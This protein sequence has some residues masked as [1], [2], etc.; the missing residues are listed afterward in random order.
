[1]LHRDLVLDLRSR[2]CKEI[3]PDNDQTRL[4]AAPAVLLCFTRDSC[5][6][7]LQFLRRDLTAV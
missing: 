5:K 6:M 3:M 4:G 7:E 1:M 2:F